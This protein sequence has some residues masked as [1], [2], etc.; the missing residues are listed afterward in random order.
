LIQRPDLRRTM[1]EAA[2]LHMQKFDWD[3]VARQ[4]QDVFE[5][6]AAKRRRH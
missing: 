1:G 2:Q 5:Q 3:I 4:W 6:A